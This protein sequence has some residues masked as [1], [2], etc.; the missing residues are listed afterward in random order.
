MKAFKLYI[1]FIYCCYILVACSTIQP[2]VQSSPIVTAAFAKKQALTDEEKK[3]WHFKDIYTDSVPGISLYKAHDFIK[4][5]KKEEII[6]AV[7]DLEVNINHKDL[8]NRTWVNTNEIPNNGIDDDNNG[9]IDDIHGWNFLGTTEKDSVLYQH[10]ESLRIVEKYRK[11][12]EGKQLSIIDSNQIANFKLY[13]K[14]QSFYESKYKEAKENAAYFRGFKQ[15]YLKLIDTM[16]VLFKTKE[17]SIAQLDSLKEKSTDSIIL[18]KIGST[19]Y[20]VENGIDEKWVNKVI[21][22]HSN[23]ETKIYNSKHKDR[24]TKDDPFNITD[25]NY[26]NNNVRGT[27][28]MSH[29]TKVAGLIAA[30]RNN[31]YGIDGINDQAK[32]MSV[33]VSANGNEYDKDI[34]LGIRYAVDNGAKIINLSIGKEFSMNEEW[35]TEAIKYAELKDVLL[36]SSAGNESINLD[37]SDAFYYPSDMDKN[38]NE[39]SNN[40]IVVGSS[41]YTKEIVSNFSNYGQTTVD[42]FAPGEDMKV[43]TRKSYTIDSGTSLSCAVVSGIASLIRSYYP[44]LSARKVKEI[45]LKSG[46]SVDADVYLP[47]PEGQKRNPN[48]VP[49]SSLS[50]SGKIVNAYNALLMAEEVS[51]KKKKK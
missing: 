24:L 3:D 15:R 8:K 30:T 12:F 48:K 28:K 23:R 31:D 29:G 5:K 10:S 1:V 4:N 26:G 19:R 20:C 32:I 13:R 17:F 46:L 7:I 37:N 45:I 22:L 18:N 36:I 47:L 2:I 33:I 42:I 43:I 41:N 39:I 40:F 6:V 49:F 35:I 21:K 34:A 27:R 50:K 11:A 14:A 25:T 38:K 16:Y 9:Y 44:N 51:M